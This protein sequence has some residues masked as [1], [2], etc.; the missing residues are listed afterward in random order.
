MEVGVVTHYFDK[1]GVAVVKLFKE[2][3]IGDRVQFKGG[4][5]DFEQ[6]IESM[7]I[8]RE[9]VKKAKSG[10]EIGIKVEQKVNKGYKVY[11]V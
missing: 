11:K 10:D 7:Q 4:E 5:V 6:I 8:Q 3:K 1:I 2:L 9:H